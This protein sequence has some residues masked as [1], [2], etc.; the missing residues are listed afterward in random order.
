MK[1][2]LEWKNRSG[3]S[4]QENLAS[5]KR[6]LEVF[7]KWTPATTVHQFLGRVD[8]A[9]GFAVI[10]SDDASAVAKDCAI[11]SPYLE[12]TVHP[13]VDIQEGARLLQQAVDFNETV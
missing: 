12:F 1:Y 3:A 9:G 10:E 4:A 6:S 5:L 13:V 8:G 11:F 2:L 7:G